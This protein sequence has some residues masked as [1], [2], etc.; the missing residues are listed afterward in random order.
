MEKVFQRELKYYSNVIDKGL[1]SCYSIIAVE[2]KAKQAEQKMKKGID[3][4]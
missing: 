1:K 3:S 4:D 2:N